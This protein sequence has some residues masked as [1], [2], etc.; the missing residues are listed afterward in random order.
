MRL[1]IL[2]FFQIGY[3]EGGRADAI[4]KGGRAD[5]IYNRAGEGG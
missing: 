2:F 1:T 3:K 4:Y 5:A